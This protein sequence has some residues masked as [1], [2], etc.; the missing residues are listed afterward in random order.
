M[1]SEPDS[2]SSDGTS[3][4]GACGH[5]W[6][7]FG[8]VLIGLAAASALVLA[9][10]PYREPVAAQEHAVMRPS[11]RDAVPDRPLAEIAAG[12]GLPMD[13]IPDARLIIDKSD[14]AL[15]FYSGQVLLKTYPVARGFGDLQ[16]KVRRDDG[17][18]PEGEFSFCER[19]VQADP[20]SWRDVW[21][22]IDYPNREDAERG[23]RDGI[24]TRA[25][26]RAILDAAARGDEPP[27]DTDLGSGV[28][29]HIGGTNPPNWTQGCIAMA[30]EHGVEVARNVAIGTPVT[31]RR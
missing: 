18:T 16:D 27:D 14:L 1:D 13:P 15:Q 6:R 24:I 21:L 4:R 31:I 29:I 17:R 25:Q 12:L 30:R 2:T 28:G 8:L 9:M 26:Y 22:Q 10:L 3:P 5:P 7:S 23:L 11:N 20:V 19:V